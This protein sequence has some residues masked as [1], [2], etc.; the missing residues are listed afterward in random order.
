[1]EADMKHKKWLVLFA[2]LLCSGLIGLFNSGI[3]EAQPSAPNAVTCPVDTSLKGCWLFNEGTGTST[4]DGS[5]NENNGELVGATWVAGRGFGYAVHLNGANQWVQVADINNSLDITGTITIAAWV[6]PETVKLQAVVKKAVTS[7]SRT[8]GYELSLDSDTGSCATNPCAYGLFNN[9]TSGN[10]YRIDASSTYT[11]TD[12]YS[13]S[14]YAVTYSTTV[15][16]LSIYKDGVL[17][18]IITPTLPLTIT[19]NTLYL[20]LG[21][22]LS[23]S[24]SNPTANHLF[25]GSLDD[26]FI[27]N[28]ALSSGEVQALYDLPTAVN[29]AGLDAAS[30]LRGL[31][32]KWQSAQEINLLGFNVLR[33]EKVDGPQ[34]RINPDLIPSENPGL[35][36]G[37]DYQFLDSTALAGRVYYYWV[38]WVGIYGS[39]MIGPV[40]GFLWNYTWL[41]LNIR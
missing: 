41:P 12:P 30:T 31:Q 14:F 2:L 18:N 7:P 23:G 38:E 19:A 40:A 6:M 32:L 22:Q 27:Y 26:I 13:W 5:G 1:M 16:T 17:S 34:V 10:M 11:I 3:V 21:A 29:I 20:G 8:D 24:G 33:A 35:L 4:A 25:K 28:R 39:E 9:K 15:N 37:N 36:Q